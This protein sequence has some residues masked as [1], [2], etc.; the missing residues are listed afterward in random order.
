[1]TLKDDYKKT[2]QQRLEDTQKWFAENVA[3]T[4]EREVRFRKDE[5][6][7]GRVLPGEY[8]THPIEKPYFDVP[9]A[10][11]ELQKATPDRLKDVVSQNPEAPFYTTLYK[12]LYPEPQDPKHQ[13]A[14]QTLS[15]LGDIGLLIGDMI[16]ASKGGDV[17]RRNSVLGENN[18]YLQNEYDRI[19]QQKNIYRQGLLNAA[20]ADRKE[21]LAAQSALSEAWQKLQ[22]IQLKHQHDL[23][24][25]Q[26]RGATQK[27]LE[28]YK[29]KNR[30]EEKAAEAALKKYIT[31]ANNAR[32]LEIANLNEKGRNRRHQEEY[33]YGEGARSTYNSSRNGDTTLYLSE[34]LQVNYNKKT[35]QAAIAKLYEL[36]DEAM[37]KGLIQKEFILPSE[38]RKSSVKE[39]IVQKYASNLY[40]AAQGNPSLMARLT[41]LLKSLTDYQ[42]G[43]DTPPNGSIS[44]SGTSVNPL[45]PKTWQDYLSPEQTP[46][47]TEDGSLSD[48]GYFN[49]KKL[50]NKFNGPII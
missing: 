16:T 46:Y 12:A 47:I 28:E 7:A 22:E 20:M 35:A 14:V 36:I 17:N 39:A 33:G 32:Y 45:N 19:A 11:T 24:L 48:Y 40:S 31:D 15:T 27:E 41:P 1:M 43:D 29:A 30:K 42:A 50:E 25:L 9:D 21:A 5:D 23:D 18:K 38:S 10:K 8:G 13:N 44:Y 3:N 49:N 37:D 4:P 2:P 26:A 6:T 34:G